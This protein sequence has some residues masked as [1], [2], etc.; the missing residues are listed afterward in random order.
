MKPK[1]IV[2]SGP[3]GL[4]GVDGNLPWRKKADLKR[5]KATTM[6]GTLV[7]GRATWDSIG[8]PLPGRKTHILTTRAIDLST[9]WNDKVG[10][11]QSLE[12][13]IA[14]GEGQ[15]WIAGGAKVY[16]AALPLCDELDVTIVNEEYQH[17]HPHGVF[18]ITV[19]DWFKGGQVEGFKVAKEEQNEEDPTLIHRTYVR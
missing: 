10:V 7:M 4:I 16:E 8:R 9:E 18:K 2:A 11:F 1:I 3:H 19:I 14:A 5:F 12:A 6:G 17:P 13:A 15:V